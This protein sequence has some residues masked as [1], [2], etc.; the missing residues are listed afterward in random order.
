MTFNPQSNTLVPIS[1]SGT[2]Q[3]ADQCRICFQRKLLSFAVRLMGA[4]ERAELLELKT[5][6]SGLFVLG[7]RVVPILA[8]RTLECDD[9]S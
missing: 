3:R 4:A 5:T 7:V 9:F 2:D 6:G 1:S 8:F